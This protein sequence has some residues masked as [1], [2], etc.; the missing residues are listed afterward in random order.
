[1]KVTILFFGIVRDIVERNQIEMTFPDMISVKALKN[2]LLADY[3][4]LK[5]HDNYAVAVNE[6]YADDSVMLKSNDIVAIIPP[7]S[8]G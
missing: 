6:N 5:K 4:D 7:V 1:M 2:S 3:P 8:G